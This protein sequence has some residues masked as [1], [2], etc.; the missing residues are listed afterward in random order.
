[1][2]WS[3]LKSTFLVTGVGV[4]VLILAIYG[5]I[6]YI[7]ISAT[8]TAGPNTTGTFRRLKR[9][10]Q[11]HVVEIIVLLLIMM[12]IAFIIYLFSI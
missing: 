5:L 3:V 11:E 7:F 9:Y 1:M 8:Y 2:L 10:I 4:L 12:V 6:L